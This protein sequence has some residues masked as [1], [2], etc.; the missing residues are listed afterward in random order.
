MLREIIDVLDKVCE[1]S[2]VVCKWE[3]SHVSRAGDKVSMTLSYPVYDAL[4]EH[5]FEMV[6]AHYMG[7]DPYS[8]LDEDPPDKEPAEVL[9]TPQDFIF[10]TEPQIIRFLML[11]RRGERFTD[12]LIESAFESGLMVAARNRLK[13]LHEQSETL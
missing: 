10:A 9:R 13:A 4:V 7:M 12:G 2:F 8:R 5:L 11:C 3:P 1:P 6:F